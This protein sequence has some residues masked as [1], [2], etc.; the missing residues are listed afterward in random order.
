MLEDL[1]A[2]HNQV[3]E[4]LDT[5]H[6]RYL[7]PEINWDSQAICL[8][9]ARGVGK[10]TLICQHL[11]NHYTSHSKALYISADNINVTAI[12]LLKIATEHFK[13]GGEAIYIDE[14]HKY[15][16][17]SQE[18]KNIIDTYRKKKIVFSGSSAIELQKSK[19]DLSRRV[20][21][22]QLSGLSFREFLAFQY[23]ISIEPVALQ[24]I[25]K[26]HEALAKQF[27]NAPILKYFQDYLIYGY[28]PFFLEGTNDYLH[29]LNNVIEKVIYEDI[30]SSENIN[31]STVI[32]LKKLLW[33]VATSKILQPNIDKIS[34]DMHVSREIIYSC[35]NYLDRSCLLKSVYPPEKGLRLVRKPAKVFLNN[36]NLISVIHN[37]LKLPVDI[38]G[39]RETFFANQIA[40]K[41]SLKTH[42]K[43]DFIIDNQYVFEVGGQSKKAT[44]IKNIKQSYLAID[45]IEIGYANRI[46]LYLFGL[47]Y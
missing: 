10:T 27:N 21:Y 46:P 36:T 11:N 14:I 20:N 3:I 29:K 22:Y 33:L 43:A 17:W 2:S 34:K 15:P 6:Q 18:I 40:E 47:M 13:Y 37:E 41:H 26:S 4:D 44:Q 30:A 23:D 19:Y 42:A 45:G 24:D 35:L 31:N 28:F 9:G 38:G 5:S 12:G 7:Y 16:N 8:L 39:V 32:I 25:L 1:I